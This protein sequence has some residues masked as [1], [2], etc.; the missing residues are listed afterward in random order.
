MA[1]ELDRQLNE[2]CVELLRLGES[3]M[4]EPVMASLDAAR[5]IELL[6]ARASHMTAPI[7]KSKVMEHARAVEKVNRERNN[8]AHS[9]LMFKGD[10]PVLAAIS[11]AKLFKQLDL[12]SKTVAPSATI[13]SLK[14][15]LDH[16]ERTHGGGVILLERLRSVREKQKADNQDRTT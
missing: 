10:T 15:A 13:N 6:K 14:A 4:A 8:A 12:K 9:V 3:K 2:I 11:A 7:W 5:K 16:A 1:S